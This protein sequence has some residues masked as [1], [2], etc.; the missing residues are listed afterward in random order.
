MKKLYGIII[1]GI[2]MLGMVGCSSN[3]NIK[4]IAASIIPKNVTAQSVVDELKAKE[5]KYMENITVYTDATD[6]NKMLGRPNQYIQKISW[7]D[8]RDKDAKNYDLLCTIEIF[9]N[10]TDATTRKTYIDALDKISPAGVQYPVEKKTAYLR[11]DGG[12]LP[13]QAKEYTDIFSK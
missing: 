11:I 6:T 9:N 3:S 1:I 12:L 8:S 2:L 10:N 7:N 13:S 4:S 5:G